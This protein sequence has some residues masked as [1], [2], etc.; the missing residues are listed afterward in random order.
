M[1]T[2]EYEGEIYTRRNSKWVD[3]RNLVVYEML[4]RI[5][6]RLYNAALN[7]NF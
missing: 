6:N 7:K 3:S 4:H 2:I 5:L 1:E